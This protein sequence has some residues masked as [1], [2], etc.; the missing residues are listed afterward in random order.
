[1]IR[2][3]DATAKELRSRN[4]ELV[5]VNQQLERRNVE[6][7][8]VADDLTNVLL[9]MNIAI[10]MLDADRR[11]RRVTPPAEKLLG[12]TAAHIGRP[13]KRLPIEMTISELDE[14]IST[15]THRL[16]EVRKDVRAKDGRWYS[17][18]IGPFLT[19]EHRIRGVLITFVDI[20]EI[21]ESQE[22]T[23]R[24]QKLLSAILDA[25]KDLLVIVLDPQGHIVQFNQALQKATGYSF[26][27]A[28]G[29]VL[30]DF[31]PVPA[32]RSKVMERFE[33]TLRGIEKSGETHWLAKS[34]E[35]R[36]F[37]WTN[38]IVRNDSGGVDYVIRAGVDETKREKA[39]RRAKDSE[40]TLRALLEAPEAIL[41]YN[42]RSGIVLVNEAAE[43][44]FGYSRTELVGKSVRMLIP[45]RL[46]SKHAKHETDFF[47]H[48]RRRVINGGLNIIGRRK[49]GSEFP[50][51][52]GLS[53]FTTGDETFAVA[54][55]TD[56]TEQKK[57]E[58][59]LL[60]YHK[61][62]QDLTARLMGAQEEERRR[63]ARQLHDDLGQRLGVLAIE[64]EGAALA[65]PPSQKKTQTLLRGLHKR[66]VKLS[67][68]VRN[69]A[70]QLHPSVLD[71]IGL[72]AA[73][74]ELCQEF[75]S[76]EGI[77]AVFEQNG[78]PEDLPK[79]ISSCLYGVAQAALH[80]ILKH[81]RASHVSVKISG[82]PKAIRFCVSDN[83]VG[84][85]SEDY[86][87][88]HGLGIVSMKERL[89][90]VH[91]EFSIHSEP[92]GGTAVRV[93]VPLATNTA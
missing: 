74:E 51:A 38:T 17:M 31:F 86:R 54:F 69:V 21:K 22:R 42:S 52:I 24:E 77:E 5:K 93:V 32:E 79:E 81:A 63:I 23:Q 1:M 27:E 89:R 33:A 58:A 49:N 11:I 44:M 41:A 82:T 60:Q 73:L 34:G 20:Q 91:G 43:A 6:L 88:R 45:E 59:T 67:E 76:R 66:I 26:E 57:T 16:I 28:K 78:V 18:R 90:L 70:H 75:S 8:R 46:Q 65:P 14:I 87:S 37:A 2:A 48:P 83:G 40:I 84:F 30:W 15:A 64:A 29:K 80:N 7:A 4:R 53:H 47:A 10:L 25:A 3:H 72:T 35:T 36:L 85:D 13:I 19:S 12:L 68:E 39:E 9:R 56:I 61:D 62:L 50:A 55:A 92:A 71:D